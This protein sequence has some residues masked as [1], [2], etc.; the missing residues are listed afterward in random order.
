M[1]FIAWVSI[2]EL[3]FSL[4]SFWLVLSALGYCGGQRTVY[5]SQ[6]SPLLGFH[7]SHTFIQDLLKYSVMN[8]FLLVTSLL[9]VPGF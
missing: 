4:A 8:V 2:A 6:F 9:S 1:F 3:V 5:M 7:G